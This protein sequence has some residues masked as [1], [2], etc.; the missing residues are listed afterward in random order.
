MNA[1]RIETVKPLEG[2]RLLVK[3]ADGAAKVYDCNKIIELE[4]F[5]LLRTDAFFRAVRVD[6][7]GYGISWNDEMDLSEFELWQNGTEWRGE[8]VPDRV[9]ESSR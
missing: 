8:D 9:S 4:P 7:G 1:P 2:K 3:F 5:R 6:E